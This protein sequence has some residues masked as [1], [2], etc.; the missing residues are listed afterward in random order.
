[1]ITMRI[2]C[3]LLSVILAV[4]VAAPCAAEQPNVVLI[5]TDD[6]GLGD[7]GCT[8]NPLVQTPNIDQ[9][10]EHSA[11]FENFYVCPVCSPTRASLLTGRYHYR[12]GVV[13]TFIGRS[14]M[15]ADEVTLAER[16]Q[17]SGYR[18]G[19]FGKWHLGDCFPMRPFDQGFDTAV[20]HRGGGIGQ[21][22]DPIGAEGKY[23]D[24]ILFHNGTA[25]QEQGYCT[26]VYYDRAIEFIESCVQQQKRFFVY[27]PDNCPHGPFRDVPEKWY[28]RY[29][30]I[31]LSAESYPTVA[32]GEPIKSSTN[33]DKNVRV[34]SMISNVD[35]NIGRLRNRL[36]TLGVAD[37]TIVIFLTDNGPNGERYTCGLK[38]RKTSV[39]EGGIRTLF[40]IH[41]PQGIKS[42]ITLSDVAAH[43][44]VTPTL[45][46][47]CQLKPLPGV[48]DLDGVSL[49]PRLTG[50]A[51]QLPERNLFLQVHRGNRPQRY[52]HM[53]VRGPRFKLV[54]HSGFHQQGFAGPPKFELFDLKQDPFEQQNIIDQHPERAAAMQ[55]A[56]DQW[57]D[58]I[59]A[60]RGDFMPPWIKVSPA[61][62]NP[63]V[64]T[65]QD[66]FRSPDSK[67]AQW[68]RTDGWRLSAAE[69]Q[70]GKATVF[71]R[72]P[73]TGTVI[74]AVGERRFEA[75][76]RQATQVELSVTVPAG[77]FTLTSFV[78]PDQDKAKP[79]Q[80]YQLQLDWK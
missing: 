21:S 77:D 13:D 1:M 65:R 34:F 70:S 56:Y 46:E 62:E 80:A 49:W 55:R 73:Q 4:L 10:L 24:P 38:G 41:W 22:S 19:I 68:P 71:F 47:A 36:A 45:I 7:F 26:D 33:A 32:G 50:Q 25:V 72:K 37:N 27:L 14:M 6:Q 17:A 78:V 29:R 48:G 51:D 67:P 9:L 59:E 28:Q 40:G 43:I 75:A 42:P 61:D 15:N 54:H 31:D 58:Q 3:L 57:F 8:G 66:A 16:F 64:L 12:T 20:V 53:T 69:P 79:Q 60:A 63:L 76:I 30:E 11:R 44:D 39:Y 52:H 23:T 18:T 2:A 74:V 35:E 5:M